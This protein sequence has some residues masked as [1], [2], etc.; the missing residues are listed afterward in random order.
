MSAPT[1]ARP[2]RRRPADRRDQLAAA[3]AGL[4]LRHGFPSVR[5]EEIAAVTGVTGPSLYRHF[6]DK[7]A[8]LG[9]IV[10]SGLGELERWT[11]QALAAPEGG[12]VAAL[13]DVLTEHAADRPAA[14]LLWRWNG[15]HLVDAHRDEMT[16]RSQ[17]LW[18]SWR[19]ALRAERPGLS[20]AAADL[21]CWALFGVIS[22]PSVHHTTIARRRCRDLL[23][24]VA[25][26]VLIVDLDAAHRAPEPPPRAEPT[27]RRDQLM[28]AAA[29]LFAERGFHAV[30]VDDI[31]A[32]VGIAGPSVYR[33]FPN[34]AAILLALSRRA[35]E[36]LAVAADAAVASGPAE[37]AAV[38]GRVVD[39]YV[40][41]IT[42][43][44]ELRAA[45]AGDRAALGDDLAE[46]QQVQRSYLDRWV[47]PLREADPSLS[48]ADARVVVHAAVTIANDL[49]RTPYLAA[50][51]GLPSELSGLLRA[52]FALS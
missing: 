39:S 23:R 25:H 27:A 42:G 16:R 5:I 41:V 45:F 52:A 50:R 9:E 24:L 38:L 40:A 31:G 14:T 47:R 49:A 30:G 32:A 33:H 17:A 19:A 11:A 46:L 1:T 48:A 26:R 4:F 2:R 37:P 12:R 21:L 3:A 36:R 15:L 35:A 44:P 29:E 10:L 34:K 7:Q 43:T 22:S 8:M 28:A 18:A 13:V 20:E 6:A 51:P